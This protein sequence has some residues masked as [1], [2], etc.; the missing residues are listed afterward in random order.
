[1]TV[2]VRLVSL[3]FLTIGGVLTLAFAGAR[4]QPADPAPFEQGQ[5]IYETTCVA[6]HQAGGAG[7]P[8]ALP[9][10]N[11][12]DQLSNLEQLVRTIRLGK[13]GMPPF[14]QLSAGD[15]AAVAT[16]IRNA[17]SNKFGPAPAEQVTTI[18]AALP[19]SDAKTVSVWSGVYNDAQIKR[20]QALY[21]GG[22]SHCHGARLNGA[23][24]SDQ[25]PSPAVARAGFLRKW[26]GRTVAELFTYVRDQMPPDNPG[27]T[28]DQQ[29]VDV[30]AYMFSVSEIPAGDR[31]LPTDRKAL[32]GI[33]I[34]A[35]KK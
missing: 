19:K 21:G 32:E 18:L 15:I 10:L 9:A 8:P 5:K 28:S 27:S 31:E 3:T 16:Y 20:G 23:G 29:A 12:N 17:W 14:S 24:Q 34:N 13:G 35:Q 4:A 11:G 30:V 22:C 2:R 7:A 25:P 6:C 33:V 1:M 26:D